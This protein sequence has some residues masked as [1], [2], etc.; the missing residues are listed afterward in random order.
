MVELSASGEGFAQRGRIAQVALDPLDGQ[1]LKILEVGSGTGQGADVD[2]A[3]DQ[4]ACHCA[5][6]ESGSTSD[7]SLHKTVTSDK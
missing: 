3:L 6:D 5:A 2:A 4:R 7:K 1:T